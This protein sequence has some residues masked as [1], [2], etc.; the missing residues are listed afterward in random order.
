ME[1][2][3]RLGVNDQPLAA[4]TNVVGSH[5]IGCQ[6]HQMCL[7]RQRA[8][9]ARRSD[10]VGTERQVRYELPV[11]HVPLDPVDAGGLER[12]DLLTQLGEVGRQDTR[13]DF[14]RS[15]HQSEGS[16]WYATPGDL[17]SSPMS[18]IV[19]RAEKMAAGGD[20]IARIADGRVAFVRGALPGELVEIEI[21][22]SKKDFVRAEV[23]DVIEPSTHR[24]VP[25]CPAHAAG[26]GGCTWQHVD[27]GAQLEMKSAVVTEA[28]TRTGRLVD[29]L[30]EIGSSVPAWS[31]RTTLRLA[32][33]RHRLGLRGR[34]SH[35]I[36][37]LDGC[38]VS[39]PLL[40]DL[41]AAVRTRG[42]GEVSL[43]VGAATGQ[44]SAWIVDGDVELSDVPSDVGV[45]PDRGGA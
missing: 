4:R 37:E 38:P 30:V 41:L 26:C 2:G 42:D 6:D 9:L 8:V 25:P 15:R 34:S 20:A 27:D 45:G 36:V 32:A 18:S 19:V 43:R 40:E 28:L 16:G 29:P 17:Q 33:G 11:H 35:D 3:A 31:Y 44:R 23:V 21:V 7:E 1:V 12:R 22:Q 24:V 39:H 10:D 5:Q 14:D 13:G